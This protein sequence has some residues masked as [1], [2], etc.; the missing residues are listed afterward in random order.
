MSKNSD[1]LGILG[2]GNR[3]TL[4]YINALNTTFNTIEKEYSTF[5]FIL[6]NTNFNTINPYLPDNFEMLLPTLS[7]YINHLEKLPV[8]HLLIPNITLHEAIDK[9]E[10]TLPILH[11]LQLSATFLKEQHKNKVVVFGTKYTMTS[12]Y[13]SNYFSSKGILVISPSKEDIEFI[14]DFRKKIYSNSETATDLETYSNLVSNYNK[15]ST[16]LIACTELSLVKN[17]KPVLDM[18]KLQIDEA[19]KQFKYH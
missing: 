1:T 4:F 2:L 3:S 5:P 6:Y 11:P 19:I 14:D 7:E 17:A 9:L 13:I 16:V 15:E 12:T 18:A 10:T 8:S